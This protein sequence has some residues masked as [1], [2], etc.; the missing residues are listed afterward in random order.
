MN[1]SPLGITVEVDDRRLMLHLENLPMMLR[2]NLR[3]AI[4]KL[5]DELLAQVRA[6]E[7][8]RTGRLQNLTRSYVDE[9]EDSVTGRVKVL[10][11]GSAHNIAAA[12]L[13]YGAHAAVS[14]KASRREG[15]AVRAYERHANIAARRFL[16]GPGEAMRARALA[17]L[18]KAVNDAVKGEPA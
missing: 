4:T 7:P 18:E 3:V 6:T 16:R 2:S 15:I 17:E 13:E 1:T 10:G 8:R 5:T 12:A 14:V 9:H 11:G